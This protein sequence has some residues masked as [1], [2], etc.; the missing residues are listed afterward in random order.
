LRYSFCKERKKVPPP[1]SPYIAHKICQIW[2]IC[3]GRKPRSKKTK[4]E[5][6][7][8]RNAWLCRAESIKPAFLDKNSSVHTPSGS[9]STLPNRCEVWGEGGRGDERHMGEKGTDKEQ[10]KECLKVKMPE[11]T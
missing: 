3:K 1:S 6:E 7:N 11:R 5:A 4:E 9:D 8:Q 10:E 2:L